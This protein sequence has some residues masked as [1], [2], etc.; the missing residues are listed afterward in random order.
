MDLC[1][2][3]EG[4]WL[5]HLILFQCLLMTLSFSLSHWW[6]L[7]KL[8]NNQT[9]PL[10]FRAFYTCV[11]QMPELLHLQ[12]QSP[13]TGHFYSG[14]LQWN[15]QQL[16][17]QVYQGWPTPHTALSMVSFCIHQQVNKP[18]PEF[19]VITCF[20]WLLLAPYVILHVLQEADAKMELLAQEI[21]CRKQLWRQIRREPGGWEDYLP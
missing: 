5:L 1:Q 15:L 13:L 9:A 21:Y 10:S 17:C 20:L 2:L 16:D 11:F 19:H 14:Y 18:V 6:A 7:I 3:L 4:F 12:G 8:T